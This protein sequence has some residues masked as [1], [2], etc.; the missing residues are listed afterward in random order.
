MWIILVRDSKSL[1]RPG[2]DVAVNVE[3]AST[4]EF[5]QSSGSCRG[6]KDAR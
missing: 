2:S 6:R 1:L 3:L 5:D 4:D